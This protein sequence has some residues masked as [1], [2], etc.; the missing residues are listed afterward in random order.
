MSETERA[1]LLLS[2]TACAVIEAMGMQAHNQLC[3]RAGVPNEY[4]KHEFDSLIEKYGIGWNAA[5]T[6]LQG[7]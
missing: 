6:T 4:G 5:L 7:R 3:D 2:Q 1:A